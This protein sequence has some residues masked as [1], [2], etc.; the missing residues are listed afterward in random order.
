MLL[1]TGV[2]SASPDG[3]SIEG[4]FLLL[5]MMGLLDSFTTTFALEFMTIVLLA[6]W[7]GL[8]VFLAT[9]MDLVIMV[10]SVAFIK[11]FFSGSFTFC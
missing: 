11:G 9:S 2:L 5:V 7:L 4:Y 6:G 10:L 8:I 3:A 1:M